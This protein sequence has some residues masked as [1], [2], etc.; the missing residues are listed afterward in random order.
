MLAW[1]RKIQILPP[2]EAVTISIE[3]NDELLENSEFDLDREGE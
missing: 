1:E 2:L 3:K